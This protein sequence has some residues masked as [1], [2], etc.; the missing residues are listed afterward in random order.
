MHLA[1]VDEDCHQDYALHIAGLPVSQGT[2]RRTTAAP[3]EHQCRD[4]P[5]RRGRVGS[6]PLSNRH[7]EAGRSFNWRT[8]PE[9]LRQAFKRAGWALVNLPTPSELLERA[10]TARAELDY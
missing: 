9:P 10:A 6:G 3:G 7:H 5:V 4:L 2:H 1:D 8:F